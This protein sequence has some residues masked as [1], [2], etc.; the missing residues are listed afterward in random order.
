MSQH[1]FQITRADALT[2]AQY[3]AAVDAALQALASTNNGTSAPGTPYA[4][5]MYLNTAA[6]DSI[7]FLRNQGNTAWLQLFTVV[8]A[9]GALSFP[10]DMKVNSITVG[11]GNNS[12]ADNTAIGDSALMSTTTGSQNVAA[13]KFALK[14]LV[15]GGFNTAVGYVAGMSCTGNYNTF[16]GAQAGN[17]VANGSGNVFVGMAAASMLA[18]GVT[19]LT[20]A[21]N[22]VYVGYTCRP[23]VNNAVNEIIIGSGSGAT[24]GGNN[25]ATIGTTSTVAT[26]LSGVIRKRAL[27]TAPA[28]AT[29]TGTTG[30]IRITSTHIYVC[31][32]TNTWVR[33]ALATW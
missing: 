3:R 25:T 17:N 20:Q 26:I 13:G 31:I 11:R 27:D 8:A 16:V 14:N 12:L 5:Q 22:C 19:A 24:G 21:N 2:G 10:V 9:T 23:A 15:S 1:D 28:S 30:E 29:A 33:A 18:D 6:A 4:N 7:L 32:A